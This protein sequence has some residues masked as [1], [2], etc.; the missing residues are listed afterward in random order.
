MRSSYARVILKNEKLRFWICARIE[1]RRQIYRGA[2]MRIL[3]YCISGILVCIVAYTLI[4]QHK[5]QQAYEDALQKT[6]STPTKEICASLSSSAFE[7]W[8]LFNPANYQ[9]YY[10][11][12]ECYQKLAVLNRDAELCDE[13]I[14]YRSLFL[15]GSAIS[16]ASCLTAVKKQISQDF[17]AKVMPEAI[18]RIDRVEVHQTSA[19]DWNITVIPAGALWGS[20]RLSVTLLNSSGQVIGP[21]DKMETQLSD[22][23]DPLLIML[24]RKNIRALVAS[25]IKTGQSFTLQIKLLLLRDDGGQLERSH[26]LP[27]QL[28]SRTTATIIF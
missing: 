7:S 14:E 24:Y 28:E 12:S 13:V 2:I 16:Q 15:N 3:A 9:A 8:L 25:P 10:F 18:H 11:R 23:T 26:L 21:L 22:R 17:A 20:Y 5:N 19:G 1:Y 4:A 27:E 6:N